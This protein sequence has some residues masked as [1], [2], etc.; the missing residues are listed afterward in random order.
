[1]DNFYIKQLKLNITYYIQFKNSSL[2]LL[3]I[4][5]KFNFIWSQN[6]LKTKIK[7]YVFRNIEFN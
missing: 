4:F 3:E 6:Y 2:F 5:L 1:M 7:L